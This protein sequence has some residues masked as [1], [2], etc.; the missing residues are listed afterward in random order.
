MN[1]DARDDVV[2]SFASGVWYRNSV[3]GGWVQMSSS[4][5]SKIAAGEIDGDNIDDLIAVWASGLWVKKSASKTWTKISSNLPTDIAAGDMSG[6]GRVDVVGSWSSGV[7]YRN[8]ATAALVAVGDVDS[9]STDDLIGVWSTGF[10]VKKSST[11]GWVKITGSVPRDIDAG[12]FRSLEA[13]DG[14]GFAKSLLDYTDAPGVKDS[15][16]DLS[17]EGPGGNK[18]RFEQEENLIP[19]EREARVVTGPGD[20]GLQFEVQENLVPQEDSQKGQE[21]GKKVTKK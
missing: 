10:W 11:L 13:A 7:W 20:P 18:F 15:N 2:A 5:A 19:F 9:D 21:K 12:L 1:G 16:V 14:E 17:N 4:P 6:D 3:T 8:S